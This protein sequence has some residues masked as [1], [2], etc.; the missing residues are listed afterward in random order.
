MLTARAYIVAALAAF[1]TLVA[2]SI[3]HAQSAAIIQNPVVTNNCVSWGANGFVKDSGV[4]CSNV[5][6]NLA[7]RAHISAYGTCNGFYDSTLIN[8][9]I[10][11]VQASGGSFLSIAGQRC[12]ISTPL[13]IPQGFTL[14]G[15][16]SSIP[17]P[18]NGS[19][20][21]PS[22]DFST[23]KGAFILS[24]Q[25]L[26]LAQGGSLQNAYVIRS[27]LG[28]AIS[29]ASAYTLPLNYTGTGVGLVGDDASIQNVMIVGFTNCLTTQ[30]QRPYAIHVR[31]DCTNGL[32]VSGALDVAKFYDVH[33]YPYIGIGWGETHADISNV[34]NNGSGL[35]RLTVDTTANFTTG[36]ILLLRS[37]LNLGNAGYGVNKFAVT[38]VDATH[39]D[40]Q[41]TTYATPSQTTGRIY[42]VP[43]LRH[44][45][46]FDFSHSDLIMC[47]DC[48]EVNWDTGFHIGDGAN[49]STVTS[50]GADSFLDPG[51]LDNNGIRIT[52][53]A[54]RAAFSQGFVSSYAYPVKIEGSTNNRPHMFN[55]TTFGATNLYAFYMDS[56][57]ATVTGSSFTGG[58]PLYVADAAS[59]LILSGV[60]SGGSAVTYQSPAD[61]VKVTSLGDGIVK[62]QSHLMGPAI[63]PTSTSA[64]TAGEMGSDGSYAYFCVG[65]NQWKRTALGAY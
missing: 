16:V 53:S 21:P 62:A 30:G 57:A 13:T 32:V 56:G 26:N 25:T 3:A 9:A 64:C 22:P 40:L 29:W 5:A 54:D 33:M 42:L 4:S 2:C 59:Q 37:D 55:N 1:W 7:Q 23:V 34:A 41:G 14:D 61:S 11:A 15:G 18:A 10:A 27:G 43:G 50:Y 51:I 28:K 24:G 49:F 63:S 60:V 17:P 6:A 46:A 31:G 12:G 58:K 44:G 45:S 8:T 20:S 36:Q 47:T 65:T 52:G 35:Y 38:V 39:L 48:F 19:Y